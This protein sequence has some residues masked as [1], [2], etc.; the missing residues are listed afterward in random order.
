[1]LFQLDRD[2]DQWIASCHGEDFVGD[3][4]D[5]L[6]ARVVVLVDPVAKPHQAHFPVLHPIQKGRDL[7]HIADLGEHAQDRLVGPA[8]QGAVQRRG[9]ARDRTV[10]VGLA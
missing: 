7:L 4:L 1:M 8:V 9:R 3:P 5:D 10:G 6:R 2:V